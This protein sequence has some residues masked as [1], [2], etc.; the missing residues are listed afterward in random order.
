M[1]GKNPAIVTAT[2]DLDEASEGVLKSAF[3]LQG[4]KCSACSRIYVDKRVAK[5][6]TD[7]LIEKTGRSSSGTPR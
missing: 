5:E 2:A 3:G 1:G 6:F 7:R 4:Q